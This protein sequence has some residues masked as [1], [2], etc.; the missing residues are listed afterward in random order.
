MGRVYGKPFGIY[1]ACPTCGERDV[2]MLRQEL[3]GE[4]QTF[5]EGTDGVILRLEPGWLCR[6]SWCRKRTR[7]IRGAFVIS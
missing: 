2:V 6:A 7:V 4:P 1:V 3:G 5:E